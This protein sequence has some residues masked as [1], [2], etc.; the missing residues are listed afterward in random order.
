MMRETGAMAHLPD[1]PRQPAVSPPNIPALWG[2]F[3]EHLYPTPHSRTEDQ[4]TAATLHD[5]E[6]QRFWGHSVPGCPEDGA[7]I[8]TAERLQ[9]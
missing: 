3:S 8:G 6:W 7:E 2:S 4:I 1:I 9:D 5:R